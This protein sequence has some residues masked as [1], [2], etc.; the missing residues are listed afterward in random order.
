MVSG[1]SIIGVKA[2]Q[3]KGKGDTPPLPE[4]Q[5]DGSWRFFH[6]YCCA[7][8]KVKEGFSD[9]VSQMFFV[10]KHAAEKNNTT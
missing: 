3:E 8:E 1:S 2:T 6:G 5:D 10:V 9:G 7:R 4:K